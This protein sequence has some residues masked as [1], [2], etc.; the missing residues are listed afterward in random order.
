MNFMIENDYLL[1]GIKP[2]QPW[3]LP[4]AYVRKD[5]KM[6]PL[7]VNELFGDLIL[8]NNIKLAAIIVGYVLG[9]ILMILGIFMFYRMR[10]IAS[11]ESLDDYNLDKETSKSIDRALIN[12][13]DMS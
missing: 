6:T 1:D 5:L 13:S 7:Q 2:T 10:K 12:R 8:A 11:I 3:L 4:Y 9:T